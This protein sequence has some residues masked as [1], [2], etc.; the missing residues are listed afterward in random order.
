MPLARQAIGVAVPTERGISAQE[1]PARL[2]ALLAQGGI[3]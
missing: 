1:M 2:H 3:Q